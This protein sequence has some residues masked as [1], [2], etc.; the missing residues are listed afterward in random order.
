MMAVAVVF[1]NLKKRSFIIYGRQVNLLL[2]HSTVVYMLF[3]RVYL[4]AASANT[5]T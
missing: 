2:R 5:R 4:Q 1:D 3:S